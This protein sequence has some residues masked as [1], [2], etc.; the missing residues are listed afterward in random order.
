MEPFEQHLRRRQPREIPPAWRNQILSTAEAASVSEDVPISKTSG[1]SLW[2]KLRAWLWPHPIAWAALGACWMIIL[3]VNLSLSEPSPKIAKR[4][5]AISSDTLAELKREQILFAE[6][7]G[8]NDTPDMDRT[9]KNAT[10]PRTEYV[11]QA[12]A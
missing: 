2:R 4:S 12:M 10:Q 1:E 3:G 5:A 9:K 6:V 7:A 11:S 8:I